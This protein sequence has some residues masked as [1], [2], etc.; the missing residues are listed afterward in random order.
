MF[1]LAARRDGRALRARHP[2]PLHGGSWGLLIYPNNTS[3]AGGAMNGSSKDFLFGW[4]EGRAG[5]DV[6]L[7]GILCL[8]LCGLHVEGVEGGR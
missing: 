5:S 8:L 3:K 4:R 7:E 6:W 1:T 2:R